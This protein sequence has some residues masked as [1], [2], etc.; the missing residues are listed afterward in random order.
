MVNFQSPVISTGKLQMLLDYYFYN[1]S[2]CSNKSVV[3]ISD[4]RLDFHFYCYSQVNSSLL[5][6][7][8]LVEEEGLETCF[9]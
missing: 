7:V 4:F 9:C 2:S 8:F 5:F 3:S 1:K 6:C